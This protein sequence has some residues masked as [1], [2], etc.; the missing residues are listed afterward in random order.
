MSPATDGIINTIAGT[1]STAFN[2]DD[3][4][5]LS[6]N[7]FPHGIAVDSKGNIYVADAG[8]NKIRKISTDGM[9]TT[10]T[11]GALVAP[12]GVAVDQYDNIYTVEYSGH[13]IKKVYYP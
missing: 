3:I 7:M 1:G 6:A 4:S 8:T 11:T 10:V 2:G 13:K 12:S 9:A 5:A